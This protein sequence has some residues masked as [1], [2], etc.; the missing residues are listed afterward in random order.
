L[1]SHQWIPIS[2]WFKNCCW[3]NCNLIP[4][5]W[6]KKPGFPKFFTKPYLCQKSFLR[7]WKEQNCIIVFPD[8]KWFL[9]KC[10]IFS[11][12][13]ILI[14]TLFEVWFRATIILMA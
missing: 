8:K 13:A 9:N 4:S 11:K 10:Y 3:K 1:T 2:F 5:Q 7:L 6:Q 14:L 12:Y